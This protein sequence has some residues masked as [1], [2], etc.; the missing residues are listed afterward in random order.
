MRITILRD[1]LVTFVNQASM[2][3]Q[4]MTFKRLFPRVNIVDV[5]NFKRYYMRT[6][7]IGAAQGQSCILG[8]QNLAF[9]TS[10]DS[11]YPMKLT[12]LFCSA[13]SAG[14]W[15]LAQLGAFFRENTSNVHGHRALE[16]AA[17]HLWI[18][19]QFLS[20]FMARIRDESA[21]A[22]AA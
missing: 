16:I 2:V 12:C 22:R 17:A 4:T 11:I 18:M 6:S 5:L 13:V 9:C 21:S 3:W 1:V 8:G 14:I 19:D 10:Y 7:L 20:Q 15:K